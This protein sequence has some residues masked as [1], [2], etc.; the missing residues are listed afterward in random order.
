MSLS[1]Y[2]NP[3]CSKSRAGLGLLEQSGQAF[4][5]ILYLDITLKSAELLHIAKNYPG[6]LKDLLREKELKEAGFSLEALTE[7]QF[8][9]WVQKTP[10][11]L[12]RPLLVSDET[13]CIG[14]P[15]ENLLVFLESVR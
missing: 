7:T 5:C 9:N 6:E 1:Y 4:N 3:N 14:R 13:V 2:H 10:K 8:V 12:Q 11:C 15:V